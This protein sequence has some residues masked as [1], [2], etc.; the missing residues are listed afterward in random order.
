MKDMKRLVITVKGGIVTGI[1]TEGEKMEV[2]VYDFDNIDAGDEGPSIIYTDRLTA[3]ISNKLTD[4]VNKINYKNNK[5]D[6]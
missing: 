4:E 5:G 2:Q 6:N 1:Y 3:R